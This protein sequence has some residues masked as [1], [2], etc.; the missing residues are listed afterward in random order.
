M[1]RQLWMLKQPL[2]FSRNEILPILCN[3]ILPYSTTERYNVYEL[4]KMQRALTHSHNN[5]RMIVISRRTI[6]KS[7]SM[8]L[9]DLNTATTETR[10]RINLMILHREG[11]VVH[12]HLHYS[13]LFFPRELRWL[14]FLL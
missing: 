6:S 11:S 2:E 8:Y 7:L 14:A 12:L 5:G 1:H 9:P 13:V 4:G 10:P 3:S